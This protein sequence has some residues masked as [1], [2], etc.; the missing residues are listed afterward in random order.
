MNLD[1]GML[2]KCVGTHVGFPKTENLPLKKYVCKLIGAFSL[3]HYMAF[4]HHP[5]Q[6]PLQN[7]DRQGLKYSPT[8]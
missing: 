3:R 6:F 4:F 1:I 5:P 8:L 2:T 7:A